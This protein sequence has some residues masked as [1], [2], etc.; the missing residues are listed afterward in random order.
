MRYQFVAVLAP[1]TINSREAAS[2]ITGVMTFILAGLCPMN[3]C[4]KIEVS[5]ENVA[6]IRF[7]HRRVIQRR[8][9]GA[10]RQRGERATSQFTCDSL[11]I[12][13]ICYVIR[14]VLCV[15]CSA[16]AIYV[17]LQ[18]SLPPS[19]LGNKN[20][21]ACVSRRIR[22]NEVI[23]AKTRLRRNRIQQKAIFTLAKI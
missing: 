13:S 1:A 9:R 11:A 21:R 5:F 23:E 18:R 22:R 14:L 17:F 10:R 6:V 7:R 3:T 16:N 19:S 8:C 12:H 4:D 15:R 20:N 2:L